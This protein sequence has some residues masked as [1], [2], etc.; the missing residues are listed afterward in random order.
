MPSSFLRNCRMWTSIVR[1]SPKYSYPQTASRTWLRDNAKPVFSARNHRR[2]NSLAV[3]STIS[4]FGVVTLRLPP[5]ISNPAIS[6]ILGLAGGSSAR[7]STAFT[8]AIN[9]RGENGF[10]T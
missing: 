6:R 1:V 7:R 3:G 10:V 9:S 5:S 4:P 8:L 2:S